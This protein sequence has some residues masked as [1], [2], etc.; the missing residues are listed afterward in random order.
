MIKVCHTAREVREYVETAPS[1]VCRVIY[2]ADYGQG[3][4]D[5]MTMQIDRR[6]GEFGHRLHRA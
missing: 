1:P 3:G 5:V 4:V 6:L 2:I